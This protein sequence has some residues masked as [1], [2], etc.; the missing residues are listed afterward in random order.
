MK[1]NKESMQN[2]QIFVFSPELQTEPSAQIEFGIS[3]KLLW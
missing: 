1:T 2:W 3:A